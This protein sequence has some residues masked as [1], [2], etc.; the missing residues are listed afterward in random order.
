LP[1][2]AAGIVLAQSGNQRLTVV[3]NW[4]GKAIEFGAIPGFA[5]G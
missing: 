2:K 5:L 1:E 3:L 4:S